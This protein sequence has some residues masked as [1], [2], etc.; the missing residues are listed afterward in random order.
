[1]IADGREINVT[2]QTSLDGCNQVGAAKAEKLSGGAVEFT[3]T[4]RDSASGQTVTVVDRFQPG[5]DDSVRWEIEVVSDGEPWTTPITTEL[6]YPA[7][8]GDAVLD[9]VVGSGVDELVQYRPADRRMARSAGVAAAGKCVL[10]LR[11]AEHQP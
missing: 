10:D 5:T 8:I 2:G 6:N 9:G 3:R 1:M 7:T 4:L 11:R